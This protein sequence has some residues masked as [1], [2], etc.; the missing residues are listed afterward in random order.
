MQRTL[1]QGR[2]AFTWVRTQ[3]KGRMFYT[4]YGHD[5]S[6]WSNPN[7]QKLIEQAVVWTVDEPAPRAC[8]DEDARRHLRRHLRRAQLREPR[9]GAEVPAAVHLGRLD[10]VHPGAGRVQ[11]GAVRERAGHHR[12]D[13]LQLRRARPVVDHRGDQLSERRAQRQP[14]RR[15]HQ[16][17]RGHQRRRARRQ[18]HGVRRPSQPAH[19]P[20]VRQR[21][22]DRRRGA[23]CCS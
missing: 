16:D 1:G 12:A 14:R 21:R 3:G 23:A 17:R 7:F 15:P 10:E 20:G 11:A 9:S 6:T 13:R 22:R 5:A 4:G 18:V 8:R 19:Q 2:E